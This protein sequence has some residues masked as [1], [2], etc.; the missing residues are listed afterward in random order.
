VSPGER[1]ALRELLRAVHAQQVAAAARVRTYRNVLIVSTV[2]LVVVALLFPYAAVWL[3]HDMAVLRPETAGAA[4]RRGDL[5]TVEAW[6]AVGGLIGAVVSLR[7][8]RASPD[9]L[10]LQAAQLALKPVAGAAIAVFG[11]VLLQSAILPPLSAVDVGQLAAYA[12][13]FGFAQEAFTGMV[14]RQAA[15]LL[16]EAKPVT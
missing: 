13:I 9:P 5:L 2:L 10:G 8:L 3:S 1:A 11:V 12:I 16:A 4:T 6:G 15:R 14:D 7:T